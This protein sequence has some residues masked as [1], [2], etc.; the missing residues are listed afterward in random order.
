MADL[1]LEER[2]SALEAEVARL[3]LE[4]EIPAQA[5]KPWWEEIRGTFKNDPIY[6]EA[7]RLGREYRESLRPK[8][9]EDAEA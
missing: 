3:K 9:D 8:D 2:V 4:R 1:S 5:Q 7:M 6:T